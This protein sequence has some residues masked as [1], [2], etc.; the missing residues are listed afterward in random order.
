MYVRGARLAPGSYTADVNVSYQVGH[1]VHGTFVF[2]ISSKQVRQTY[3]STVPSNAPAGVSSGSSSVPAWAI[4][5]GALA[6]VAVSIGGSAL[7]FRR[8]SAS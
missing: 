8:R 2:V 4:G 5:L 7:Y 1:H 3:G 6:L